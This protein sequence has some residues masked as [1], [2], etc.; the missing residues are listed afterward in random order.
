M[1]M[2]KTRKLA[3]SAAQRAQ[4][5]R[6][7]MRAPLVVTG[8]TEG[9]P[10]TVT[11]E[12]FKLLDIDPA[13]QRGDTRSINDIIRAIQAGGLVLDPVHLCARPWDQDPNK[14]WVV[15]GHQRV[16]AC[17]SLNIP[18]RALV[19]KSDSLEAEMTFFQVLN[20]RVNVTTNLL[21][22]SWVGK[23]GALLRSVERDDR[24]PLHQRVNLSAYNSDSRIPA[25]SLAR[26]ALVA[27]TGLDPQGPIQKAL[28]RLDTA[29]EV[30]A[31]QVAMAE[32]YLRLV[33]FV[34]Q[35]GRGPHHLI[36]IALGAVAHERWKRDEIMLP[37]PQVI[38]RLARVSW[39]H[40]VPARVKKY[41]PI[42]L[43]LIRKIWKG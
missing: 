40:E 27:C 13:Y 9:E 17:Q 23:A 7:R 31:R 3:T 22:K 33:G 36:L 41:Q 37:K 26:G 32:H 43:D 21:V 24:H 25:S 2:I 20:N 28:Q 11:Q 15:D 18:F 30:G 19:H 12:M 8:I 38:E 10:L 34:F 6:N 1:T 5:A 14:L 39:D 4:A 29:L 42:T 16:C 35:K